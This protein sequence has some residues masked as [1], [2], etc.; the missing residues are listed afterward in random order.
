MSWI[1]KDFWGRLEADYPDLKRVS[2]QRE[3]AAV[4]ELASHVGEKWNVTIQ[5]N[6]PANRSRSLD[7][8][9]GHENL[10][11][12]VDSGKKK[13]VNVSEEDVRRRLEALGCKKFEP[14]AHGYEGFRASPVDSGMIICLPGAVH[15]WCTVT[16]EV[17]GFLDWLFGEAYGLKESV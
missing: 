13:F 5:V 7:L 9:V 1:V 4:T 11:L 16:P 2:T 14:A 12:F 15:L 6:L 3:Y 10:S 8:P 17:L